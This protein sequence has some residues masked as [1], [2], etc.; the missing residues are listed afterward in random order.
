[1]G[2][3]DIPSD[4]TDRTV[5]GTTAPTPH[6]AALRRDSPNETARVCLPE[7]A[8]RKSAAAVSVAWGLGTPQ[9]L[10]LPARRLALSPAPAL[11]AVA[12]AAGGQ[13]IGAGLIPLAQSFIE[14]TRA[15]GTPGAGGF[16]APGGQ[17]V[18]PPHAQPHLR[19]LPGRLDRRGAAVGSI[20]LLGYAT[21]AWGVG[22]AAVR[23]YEEPILATR[24]RAAG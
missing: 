18:L 14:F 15:D 6:T 8:M 23:F 17:R 5:L 10:C 3:A 16:A 12:Q 2:E 21:V 22:A 7:A 13:L 1:M 20:G 24:E 9:D 19:R 4:R 11:W